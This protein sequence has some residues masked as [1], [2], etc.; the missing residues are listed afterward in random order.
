MG[1]NAMKIKV[2]LHCEN[3]DIF[4]R[5]ELER[6]WEEDKKDRIFRDDYH[7]ID[8]WIEECFREQE[9]EI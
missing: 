2:Y 3:E 5:K 8:E 1:G 6:I 9:I 4:S 7:S